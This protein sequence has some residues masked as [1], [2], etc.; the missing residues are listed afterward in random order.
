MSKITA[1]K[2][3]Q[4][5]NGET[6]YMFKIYMGVDPLTGKE[7]STTRRGFKKQKEAEL[8]Y[9]RLK[10]ESSNGKYRKQQYKTYRDIYDQWIVHYKKTVEESTFDKTSGIFKNHILPAMGDYRID[11]IN[12]ALCQQHVDEWV[13]KLIRFNMVK[14]YASKVIDYAIKLDYIQTNPFILVET[15]K[16]KVK[17]KQENYYVR[18]QLIDFLNAAKSEGNMKHHTF[19]RLLGFTGMRKSE[20][21]ALTWKDIDFIHNT[22]N[23]NKALGY[24]KDTGLYV[25]STKTGETRI[26]KIDQVTIDILKIWREKQFTELQILG[27]DIKQSK[28]L[29]FSNTKNKHIYPTKTWNWVN[30]LRMKYDLEYISTHGFRHTHATL[31]TEAGASLVGTQQRLGHSGNDTTTA[32]YIHVTEK[33]KTETLEKFVEYMNY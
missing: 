1:I 29:V 27:F 6:R 9:N 12:Y 8:A 4:L 2:P 5:K 30:D 26:I 21:L 14:S 15:P 25:K 13:E 10:F 20:A 24:S 11:K 17:R 7:R 23:I 18:E 22:I 32:T 31:L 3:Y 19:F 16:K 33:I 28:Q